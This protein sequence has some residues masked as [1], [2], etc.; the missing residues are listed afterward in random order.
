MSFR[1]ADG[2]NCHIIDVA[3]INEFRILSEVHTFVYLLS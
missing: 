2:V 3:K 1:E